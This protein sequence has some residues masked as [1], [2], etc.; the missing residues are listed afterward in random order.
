MILSDSVG[1]V[2]DGGHEVAPGKLLPVGRV[3]L[4]LFQVERNRDTCISL[5]RHVRATHRRRRTPHTVQPYISERG[6]NFF[7]FIKFFSSV[8]KIIKF[9]LIGS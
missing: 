5:L 8:H 9:F 4:S 2:Y 7:V 6:L 1:R 3:S